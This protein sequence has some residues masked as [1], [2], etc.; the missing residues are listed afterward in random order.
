VVAV[1]PGAARVWAARRARVRARREMKEHVS[2]DSISSQVSQ[3]FSLFQHGKVL[4][5]ALCRS[6]GGALVK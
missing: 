2:V 1:F 3:K 4:Y 6:F 5:E